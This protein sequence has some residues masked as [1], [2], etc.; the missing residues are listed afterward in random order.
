[1]RLIS[2]SLEQIRAQALALGFDRV[3]FLPAQALPEQTAQRFDAWLAEGRH[4][5]LDYM[6]R[7]RELRLDPQVL[8]PGTQATIIVLKNYHQPLDLLGQQVRIARYAHGDDYHD[9]LRAR[10]QELGRWIEQRQGL[11]VNARPVVDSAPLLERAVAALGGLGWVGKNTMLIHREIGSYFFIA[12]LLVDVALEPAPAPPLSAD[13]CGSCSR[14]LD[15]CPTGA[16][17]APRLLDARRCISYLTIELKG[18]I[19]KDLRPLIGDYLFGCDRCQD[20]CPWNSK[21]SPTQDP[22]LVARARYEALSPSQLLQMTQ[23]EFSAMFSKSAIK[24]TKRRGLLRNAAVVMGN[25]ETLSP[26]ELA[27]LLERLSCE[28]E[29]LVREHLAWAVGRH[30]DTSTL[31]ALKRI[32]AQEREPAVLEELALIIERLSHAPAALSL[33][34]RTWSG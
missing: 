1:M 22:Q 4:G 34:P 25:Q 11:K 13:H 14:C 3:A 29:P 28:P 20:V 33:E 9:V 2:E 16:L 24:R 26:E 21:A 32:Y 15:H 31:D 30:A 12:Q 10:L 18:A 27:L 23:E 7:H 5:Q 6:A 19:P 8:E 17:V